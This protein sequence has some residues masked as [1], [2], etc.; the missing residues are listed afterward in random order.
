[1]STHRFEVGVAVDAA[2]NNI[3]AIGGTAYNGV[4]D[5]YTPLDT[6]EVYNTTTHIWTTRQHMTTARRYPSVAAV[7][8]KIYAIGGADDV[9]PGGLNTVEEY[10]P[11][12]NMWNQKAPIP[13]PRGHPGVAVLNGKI[14]VVGGGNSAGLLVPIVEAYDPSNN[15]WT[16]KP[17]MPTARAQLGSAVVGNTLYAVGG[18]SGGAAKVG[19]PFI[20]QITATNNPTSYDA[21]PLPTGLSVDHTLGLISGVPT[22]SV[23]TSVTFTATNA[24]GTGSK[25]V[26]FYVEPAPPPGPLI[27]SNTSATGRIGQPFGPNGSG[28]KVLAQNASSSARFAAGGLPPGL[29]SIDPITGLISG[30]PTLDGNFIVHLGITDGSTTTNAALQLTFISDPGSTVPILTSPST[31]TLVPN[32]PF[33]YTIT[34]DANAA[35]TLIQAPDALHS[36]PPSLNFVSPNISSGNYTGAIIPPTPNTIKIRPPLVAIVQTNANN[37]TGNGTGTHPLNFFEPAAGSRKPNGSGTFDVNL[38]LTGT[39]GVESRSGGANGNHQVVFAFPTAVTSFSNATVTPGPGG[40][41]SVSSTS[42]NGTEVIVNLT[43]VSNGQ[44][45]TVTLPGVHD[46]I[47]ANAVNV[48]VQMGILV[49]DV[50]GNGA[51]NSSDVS[52]VKLHSGEPITAS[53]FLADVNGNGTINSTDI[54]LVK[55]KSGSSLPPASGAFGQ[56]KN[57]H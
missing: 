51:I 28:F 56:S 21:F 35:F 46:G 34:A 15:M 7:G 25:V 9:T 19:Q 55:S 41:A 32:Q 44:W 29:S 14:Y 37:M 4:T 17:P 1:M 12:M 50:T 45:L 30:T 11:V 10:D 3:Y 36:L 18:E 8:G 5:T 31:A 2:N 13:T 49:G 42:A 52:L 22:T 24:S 53:N 27:V 47:N 23:D 33:T 54:S 6:V 26:R 40:S 43:N 20:Y 16:S 48:T 57:R 39:P 38:P